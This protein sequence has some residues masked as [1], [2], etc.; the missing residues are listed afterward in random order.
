MVVVEFLFQFV[1]ACLLDPG[2]RIELT[3]PFRGGFKRVPSLGELK[4]LRGT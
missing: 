2:S 4:G 1:L 3:L